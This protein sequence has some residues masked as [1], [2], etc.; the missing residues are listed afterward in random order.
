[1]LENSGETTHN[2]ENRAKI[3]MQEKA[4]QTRAVGVSTHLTPTP[5]SST[6]VTVTG[7]RVKCS[8]NSLLF[9]S[10][11]SKRGANHQVRFTICIHICRQEGPAQVTVG[12]LK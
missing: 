1:M 10:T 6:L 5:E 12:I 8:H 7:A 11:W 3:P 2:K 9:P 4:P